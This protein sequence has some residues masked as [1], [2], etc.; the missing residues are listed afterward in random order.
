VRAQLLA[1]ATLILA[2]GAAFAQTQ[3]FKL[4]AEQA[5][6]QRLSGNIAASQ[7]TV[8]NVLARDPQNFS[9]T[10]TQGLLQMDQGDAKGAVVTLN[11]AI[12]GLKGQ[13]PPDWTI[14]NALGYALL[15]LGRVDD[16]AAAFQKVYACNCV[17]DAASRSKLLNNMSL[18]YRLKGDAASAQRYQSEAA[19]LNRMQARPMVQRQMTAAH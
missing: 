6:Q 1:A 15:G 8:R 19:A 10:Y 3:P 7:M 11:R 13:P 4:Q 18:T 17:L 12:A 9:A 5:R 2:S 16:A 14:Y